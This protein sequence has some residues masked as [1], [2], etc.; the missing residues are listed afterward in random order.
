MQAVP[1]SI[2]FYTGLRA[3][4]GR[5]KSGTIVDPEDKVLI[6][7]IRERKVSSMSNIRQLDVLRDP[8]K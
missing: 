6:Y 8:C 2:L 7:E 3:G 4:L 1:R 5:P